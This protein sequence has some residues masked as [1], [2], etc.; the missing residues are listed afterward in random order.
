VAILG[1]IAAVVVLEARRAGGGVLVEIVGRV[2]ARAAAVNHA[3][4]V[5]G[6]VPF[7][8]LR[9]GFVERGV[10]RQNLP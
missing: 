6:V 7:A 3:A 9:A 10:G 5:A 2:A 8:A 1:H 4:A